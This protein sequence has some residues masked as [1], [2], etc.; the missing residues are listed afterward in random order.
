MHMFIFSK[1]V[2]GNA[3]IFQCKN[4]SSLSHSLS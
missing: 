4:V 1:L 2:Y 3:I